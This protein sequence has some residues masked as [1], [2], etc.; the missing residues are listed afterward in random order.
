LF[1]PT[2]PTQ[3]NHFFYRSK[4]LISSTWHR[5]HQGLDSEQHLLPP[6][7]AIYPS[8]GCRRVCHRQCRCCNAYPVFEPCCNIILF[9]EP[10]CNLAA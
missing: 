3:S 2:L 10:F 6:A 4:L 5:H 1:L 8:F 9:R 7:T